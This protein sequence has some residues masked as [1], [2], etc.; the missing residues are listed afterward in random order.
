MYALVNGRIYSG[1]E[2]LDNH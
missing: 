1:H 2:V